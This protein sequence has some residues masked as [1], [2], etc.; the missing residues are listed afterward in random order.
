MEY[1]V[2]KS[3]IL[4]NYVVINCGRWYLKFN[5]VNEPGIKE[6]INI[7][8]SDDNRC[9]MEGL[10]ELENLI[11]TYRS[12]IKD[13]PALS[14]VKEED[15]RYYTKTPDTK[16]K[17]LVKIMMDLICKIQKIESTLTEV[18]ERLWDECVLPKEE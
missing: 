3:A 12:M 11:K 15:E 8:Y 1:K 4:S 2:K 17:S 18:Q 13:K 7:W 16:T 9:D 6:G 5:K 10:E 14:D